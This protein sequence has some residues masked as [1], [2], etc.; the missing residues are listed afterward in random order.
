MPKIKITLC[1]NG[2]K[3]KSGRACELARLLTIRHKFVCFDVTSPVDI[4]CARSSLCLAGYCGR[5]CSATHRVLKSHRYFNINI[6]THS[7]V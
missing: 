3:V 6:F 7:Y 5:N 4:G 1:E 2:S